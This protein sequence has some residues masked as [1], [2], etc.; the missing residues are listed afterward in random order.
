[1][2]CCIPTPTTD[3][4]TITDMIWVTINLPSAANRQGNV[5]EIHIVWRV[6]TLALLFYLL[7]ICKHFSYHCLYVGG[8]FLLWCDVM[9]KRVPIYNTMFSELH[10]YPRY[11]VRVDAV[12]PVPKFIA[13]QWRG[14]M[15]EPQDAAH[16]NNRFVPFIPQHSSDMPV[17]IV[18]SSDDWKC[19]YVCSP[20]TVQR[21]LYWVGQKTGLFLRSDNFALISD[22]KV[23]NTSKVSEFCPEWNA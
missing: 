16:C 8:Y 2:H 12:D 5:R 15:S 10:R 4:K 6:V 17:F 9:Q 20:F 23:C 19:K 21:Q 11:E 7:I 3:S 18:Y 22:R 1:M 13:R 14:Q